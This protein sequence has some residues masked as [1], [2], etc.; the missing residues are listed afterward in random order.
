MYQFL[1][2]KT[3]KFPDNFF[4]IFAVWITMN[5]FPISTSET[6]YEFK[7]LQ[8]PVQLPFA[9]TIIKAQS[10]YLDLY[11][12]HLDVAYSRIGKPESLYICVAKG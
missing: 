5:S 11:S 8:F 4:P 1:H 2:N 3:R 7:C 12:P 9:V 6:L 10:Q